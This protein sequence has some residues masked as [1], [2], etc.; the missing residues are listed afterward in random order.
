M[1]EAFYISN[2]F[3]EMQN[4]SYHLKDTCFYIINSEWLIKWKKYVNYDFY[5][6]ES[7]WKNFIKLNILQFRS[8][9]KLSQNNN[10]LNYINN[11]TKNK[12]FNYFDSFFLFDNAKYY[13]G[14]I[15]NK[16]LLVDREQKNSYFNR[17]QLL[18]NYNY[19][20]LNEVINKENYIWVTEDIWKYFY[21]IYGGF[22]IRRHNL[23]LKINNIIK[24][25][26]ILE[27]KLK[28]FNLIL[29]HYNITIK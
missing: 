27:P 2:L 23:S 22:E 17:N 13:P 11:K 29:F 8:E 16:I 21:C 4:T 15:N 6:N 10:Y 9:D 3:Y 19:N 12:I 20:V 1:F 28:T 25:E 5:T 26:I 7:G 14:Y 24:N 18:S